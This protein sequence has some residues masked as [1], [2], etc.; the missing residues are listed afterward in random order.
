MYNQLVKTSRFQ[1]LAIV[2][3][4]LLLP[5]AVFLAPNVFVGAQSQDPSKANAGAPLPKIPVTAA[6]PW[7]MFRGNPSL[8]GVS[9]ATL[10]DKPK[11]A[12]TFKAGDYIKGSPVIVGSRA[13]ITTMD[14]KLFALE[15]STGKKLWQF[16]TDAPIPTSPCVADNTVF[17][18]STDQKLIA[19]NAETGLKLWEYEIPGAIYGGPT[20]VDGKVI[21]PSGDRMFCIDAKTQKEVWAVGIGM[22]IYSAASITG[23]SVAFGGCDGAL[24]VVALKDGSDLAAV[25]VG[26]P[27]Q[28]SPALSNGFAYFG[29]ANEGSEVIAADITKGEIAWRFQNPNSFPFTSTPAVT[30]TCVIAGGHDKY[31]HCLNR[32]DGKELWSFLTRGEI[33]SSPIVAND[34]IVFGSGDG[35]VYIVSLQGK[36]L[37]SYEIGSPV[38]STAAVTE[39]LFM[40]GAADGV[41]YCFS[42]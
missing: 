12:W 5:V 39:G 29:L 27:V 17:I 34:R 37:W 4:L 24:H 33:D 32:A 11:L 10:P 35:R 2:A 41:L 26:Q 13:Y 1:L 19:L 42:Y 6:I 9:K 28:C 25:G 14:G 30:D 21:C 22:P 38:E 31:L 15:L 23:D 7:P 3:L 16:E 40:I 18:A 20:W 36:E 8:T